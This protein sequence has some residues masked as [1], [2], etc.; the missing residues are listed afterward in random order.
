MKTRSRIL[1]PWQ[2]RFPRRKALSILLVGAGL[3]W[4]ILPV[5][6]WE[7]SFFDFFEHITSA[8]AAA[9][10]GLHTAL[11][12][13]ADTLFSNPAGL[14]SVDR[15]LTISQSILSFYDSALAIAGETFSGSGGSSEYRYGIYS[16]WGPL[17]FSYLNK[18]RGFGIFSSSN[19]TVRTWGPIPAA[20]E[21]L[22]QNLVL[23]AARAFRIPLPERS[24]STLDVGLSFVG[25]MTA[26]GG[27]DTDIRQVIQSSASFK[28]LLANSNSADSAM[29]L[30]VEFGLRYSLKDWFAFGIAGRNLAF[31]QIRTYGSLQDVLSG[32]TSTARYNFLPLYLSAGVLFRPPMGRLEWFLNDLV[33]A[34]DYH[35]IFDFLT[36]PDGAT[37]PLL[38]I[39]LGLELK[40]LDIVSLRAGYYQALP[41]VGFGL[42]L[43]LFKLDLAYFGREVSQEPGTNPIECFTAGVKFSY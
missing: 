23:I 3:L 8:R 38:H 14:R 41:S 31:E 42:D 29:G 36:Y 28:D 30:G 13:D 26:R 6:A 22:E 34:A 15:Q 25:F 39:A 5:Q 24:R 43:S 35:N 40:L 20:N 27:S 9:M 18:G 1:Y 4:G 10:G 17:G 16:L 33:F 11:A 12:D 19:L 7:G 2:A 21:T 32:G 37:N